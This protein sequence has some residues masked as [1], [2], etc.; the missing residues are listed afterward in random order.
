M[1]HG[2]R[3]STCGHTSV[4]PRD[5]CP[6]CGA[7]E[8]V[9]TTLT[10]DARVFAATWI[11]SP[12]ALE[13]FGA[14]GFAVAW[15]DLDGGPRVQVLAEGHAPEPGV[16]GTVHTVVLEPYSLPVFRAEAP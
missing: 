5:I 13:G 15:V 8:L 4:P 2:V 10:G 11:P 3:C 1:L 6:A 14:D 9:E 7:G 12:F 16:P